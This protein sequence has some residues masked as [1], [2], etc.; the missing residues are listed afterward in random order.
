M[1]FIRYHHTES[2]HH[3]DIRS[4]LFMLNFE[5][6]QELLLVSLLLTLS[7]Y[8]FLVYCFTIFNFTIFVDF[9]P[10]LK[11]CLSQFLRIFKFLESSRTQVYIYLLSLFYKQGSLNSVTPSARNSGTRSA[12]P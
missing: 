7:I 6:I 2:Y 5:H 11:L 10:C 1:R 8:W 9:C 12:E 4:A 3:I